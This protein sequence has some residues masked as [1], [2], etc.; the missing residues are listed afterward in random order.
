MDFEDEL[1]QAIDRGSKKNAVQRATDQQA[2]L[3][4]EEIRNRHNEYRLTLSDHIE[5]CLAKLQNHFPGFDYETIYGERGWGGAI[6]RDDLALGPDGKGG[7]F[8]SRLEI[9]VRPQNEYN[10]VNITGKGTVKNKEMANW[11][12]YKEVE[13]SS[14]EEF[15]KKIDQWILQY[16]EQFAAG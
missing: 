5:K 3:S 9:T 15:S 16:A 2:K 7:S 6:S 12:Y 13:E 10:V 11:N 8:F 4:K 1:Q 14:I